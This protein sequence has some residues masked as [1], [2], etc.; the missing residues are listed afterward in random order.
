[1]NPP[2][3][4]V[5]RRRAPLGGHCVRMQTA[6]DILKMRLARGDLSH[7]EYAF[8]RRKALGKT[9]GTARRNAV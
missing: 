2:R 5:L 6:E 7:E 1:M 8:L 3:H 4:P 9:E